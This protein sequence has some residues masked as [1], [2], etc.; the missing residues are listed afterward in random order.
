L[1][2]GA[3]Y[4]V[5]FFGSS[6]RPSSVNIDLAA[7]YA[8][9]DVIVTHKLNEILAHELVKYPDLYKLYLQVELPLIPIL[10][11]MERNGVALDSQ[12]LNA[13]QIDIAKQ[14]MDIQT[15][16]FEL[17]GDAFNLESPKQIQHIL[18]SASSCANISLSLCVTI[19]SS[20]A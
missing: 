7:P 1:V 15:K 6:P 11:T 16:A 13:Q 20:Q 12:A 4:G 9:E 5:F 10:V 3:P 18:F 8:C 19:T 2:D 14:M 17:A